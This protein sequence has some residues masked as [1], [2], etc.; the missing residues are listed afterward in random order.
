MTTAKTQPYPLIDTCANNKTQSRLLKQG[1]LQ[2]DYPDTYQFIQSLDDLAEDAET[3]LIVALEFLYLMGRKS[4]GTYNRFRNEVERLC[5]YMWLV[6]NKSVFDVKR[7]DIEAYIEFIWNPEKPW[8]GTSVQ[9]RFFNK[10]GQQAANNNWRPFVATVSKSVLKKNPSAKPNIKEYQMSQQSLLSAFTA[11]SVFYQHAQM[12]EYCEANF[13]PIVK[14]NC[15]YLIKQA[16]KKEPDSLSELQWEYVLGVTKDLADENPKFERHLFVIATLK[17]LYLR[18]S[19]LSD[20]PIR[21]PVMAHFH[22]D[23]DG[24]WYLEVLGKGNKLR[25]VTVPKAYID[26]LK[27]YRVSRGLSPLPSPDEDNIPILHKL[28]GKGSPVA[29]QIRRIVEDSFD[30]AII[31]LKQDGFAEDANYLQAA[32]THWLRHT[33]ASQDAGKRPTKHL[34]DDL[35]HASSATTDEVYMRSNLKDR[36]K[37]GIDRGV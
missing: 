24:F 20:R 16:T 10:N 19:E 31:K 8:I 35:G 27:R 7:S 30:L 14:K 6:R 28:K 22:S 15:P 4:Q 32:T 33:G 29:R 25:D 3:D 11:L 17:S 13:V 37:S 1:K 34:A 9:H 5:L 21:K 12:E 36:A 23:S 18:V 26:Y 2:Q